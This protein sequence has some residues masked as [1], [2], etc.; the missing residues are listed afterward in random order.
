MT[1]DKISA[2]K[3]K[4]L[5]PAEGLAVSLRYEHKQ[6]QEKYS[7][8]KLPA[9]GEKPAVVEGGGGIEYTNFTVKS[10]SKQGPPAVGFAVRRPPSKEKQIQKVVELHPER[11]TALED[12]IPF[13]YQL[14]EPPV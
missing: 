10:A 9:R 2:D 12:R 1:T 5:P 14:A 7:H 13:E 3:L 6:K 11:I 4:P 8:P